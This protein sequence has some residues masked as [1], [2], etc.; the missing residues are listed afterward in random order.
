VP[1]EAVTTGLGIRFHASPRLEER[2]SAFMLGEEFEE[3]ECLRREAPRHLMRHAASHQLD[4]DSRDVC[5]ADR[6]HDE[7]A[8]TRHVEMQR[9]VRKLGLPAG[10]R[11]EHHATRVTVHVSGE[12]VSQCAKRYS[13]PPPVD[14]AAKP[15][16][17]LELVRR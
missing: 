14:T 6:D 16:G 11:S 15:R 5:G 3:G 1:R 8:R 17:T 2:A 4:V 9:A 10:R 12:D 13:I 7:V